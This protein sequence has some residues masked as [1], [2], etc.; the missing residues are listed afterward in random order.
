MR[1]LFLASAAVAA[2]FVLMPAT[3]F[4]ADPAGGLT[5]KAP[6]TWKREADR[7]MRAATYAIPAQKGDTEPGELGIFYFGPGQGGAVQ[8]NLDRWVNQFV[9]AD[10]SPSQKHA[11]SSQGQVKGMPLTRVEVTGT[12]TAGG[13]MM[14]GAPPSKKPGYRLLGAI[15]EG[16]EGAV[17]FKL[18]GPD[19]TVNAARKDF[20]ALLQSVDARS[21]PAQGS[22][23]P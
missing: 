3:A 2:A 7:P 4:A 9:Q 17:F 1:A 12:Y 14:M 8:A 16:P 5:W 21:A 19:K 11:K 15:V 22:K 18:T 20:D 13:G 6:D 10:G 23:R